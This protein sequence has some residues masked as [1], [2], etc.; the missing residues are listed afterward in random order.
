M[1]EKKSQLVDTIE[2]IESNGR[3][4]SDFH[5]IDSLKTLR[6]LRSDIKDIKDPPEYDGGNFFDD[7]QQTWLIDVIADEVGFFQN[8]DNPNGEMFFTNNE[9][10]TIC[11]LFPFG[12]VSVIANTEELLP[13]GI[14]ESVDG[15]LLVALTDYSEYWEPF[16]SLVRHMTLTGDVIRD[17]SDPYF[18]DQLFSFPQR[19]TQNGNSDICIVDW[20]YPVDNLIILSSLG[21]VKRKYGGN[22]TY[23]DE[24][25]LHPIKN[26]DP[27]DVAC[28]SFW[29]IQ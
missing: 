16:T 6:Q 28:D 11:Q 13:Q 20:A 26:F 3:N 7:L 5:L 19:I 24:Y 8:G 18:Q 22:V 1:D 4:M 2:L 10:K 27:Y 15:G 23:D 14:C 21:Q 12:S 9:N 25:K 17:I 29:N